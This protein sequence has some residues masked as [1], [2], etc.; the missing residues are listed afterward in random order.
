LLDGLAPMVILEATNIKVLESVSLEKLKE[1]Q[2]N[3]K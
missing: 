1:Y 2:F 3:K